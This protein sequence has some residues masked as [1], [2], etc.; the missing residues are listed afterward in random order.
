MAKAIQF[1]GI[2]NVLTAYDNVKV[3]AWSI[4]NDKQ[5]LTKGI[6]KDTLETFLQALDEGQSKG[7]YTLRVYEE[8]D[9]VRDIK[10]KTDYDGSFNFILNE[11]G[12]GPA[13]ERNSKILDRLGAIEQKLDGN[14]PEEEKETLGSIAMG[15]LKEPAQ[16]AQM[17]DIGRAL[18]GLQPM[19]GQQAYQQLPSINNAI[20]ATP[21]DNGERIGKALIILEKN[22]PKLVEHLEKLAHI[23]TTNKMTF[24]FLLTTLENF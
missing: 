24:K 13:N 1:R 20:G 2:D 21:T 7:M 10:A 17:I 9:N 14:E 8:I 3:E 18:L 23:S 4:W 19:Y 12:P 22:D 11:Y 5:F 15:L 6:G 16:L